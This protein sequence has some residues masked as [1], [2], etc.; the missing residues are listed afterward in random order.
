[1]IQ[2]REY[3]KGRYSPLKA[4]LGASHENY[5][6]VKGCILDSTD[7]LSTDFFNVD[8]TACWECQPLVTDLLLLGICY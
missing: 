8:H 4:P 1:M 6:K 3:F 5:P 2:L 7:V